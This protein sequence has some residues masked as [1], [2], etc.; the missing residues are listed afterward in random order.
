MFQIM[1]FIEAAVDRYNIG[2]VEF[3]NID[4]QLLRDFFQT[5]DDMMLRHNTDCRQCT[6]HHRWEVVDMSTCAELNIPEEITIAT[7][8]HLI[9]Y[10]KRCKRCGFW[11]NIIQTGLNCRLARFK[12]ETRPESKFIHRAMPN[13]RSQ[14][15]HKVFYSSQLL[16]H[17][18]VLGFIS[19]IHSQMN[20]FVDD[21]FLIRYVFF[22]Y[23]ESCHRS[24]CFSWASV[25]VDKPDRSICGYAEFK[26][27]LQII[28]RRLDEIFRNIQ[29]TIPIEPAN[30][31]EIS[32]SSATTEIV[33]CRY[34]SV[35]T[36]RC[37][38]LK[39]EERICVEVMND[40]FIKPIASFDITEDNEHRHTLKMTA[41]HKSS[42]ELF[43]IDLE[44]EAALRDRDD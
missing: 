21:S 13:V 26:V 18:R 39:F 34:A 31:Y 36:M 12:D 17:E 14:Y 43:N 6:G 8:N 44:Q 24:I 15:F 23:C 9:I 20:A 7:P 5:I 35:E 38:C 42:E 41:L 19:L 28:C 2:I 30:E 10:V 16:H 27:A 3:N 22:E 1:E 32:P 29:L 25:F 40:E 11:K 37:C 33:R 4:Y